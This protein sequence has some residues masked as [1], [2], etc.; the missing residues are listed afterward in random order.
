M[1]Y[2]TIDTGNL[3]RFVRASL[4]EQTSASLVTRKTSIIL[5]LDCVW[6][7]FGEADRD[8]LLPTARV[9]VKFAGAVTSLAAEFF[10]VI[11]GACEGFAHDCVFEPLTLIHVTDDARL[12]PCVFAARSRCRHFRRFALLAAGRARRNQCGEDE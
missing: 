3:S 1:S 6:G 9:D 4:P 12:T 2:V 5:F 11:F 8:C 10:C 7:I